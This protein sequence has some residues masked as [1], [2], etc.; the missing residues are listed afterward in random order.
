MAVRSTLVRRVSTKLSRPDTA[1]GV[2]QRACLKLMK[3][4]ERDG[5]LPTNIRFLF[6]ELID[7]GAILKDDGRASTKLSEAMMGLREIGLVPWSAIIDETRELTQWAYAASV[8]EGVR[9]EVDH[10][11]IDLW[12][13]CPPLVL[14]ESRSLAGVLRNLCA[15][16]LV[17]LASTNGQCGGFLHATI[18]PSLFHDQRVLYFGDFDFSGGHIEANTRGVLERIR[19]GTLEWERLAITEKQ[20]K[21]HKLTVIMKLDGRTEKRNPAVE[22]EA[23]GQ[24]TIIK[25]LRKRLIEMLPEPLDDVLAREEA[26]RE[27]VHTALDKLVGKPRYRMRRG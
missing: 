4:H 17:S 19:N 16:Y 20:I 5:T 6:Y 18:A 22:T 27:Q 8:M 24:A 14:T 12:D 7:R 26:Q 15:E 21:A 3:E 23:L 11:R 1:A 10:Q 13:G 9:A 25:I 2:L